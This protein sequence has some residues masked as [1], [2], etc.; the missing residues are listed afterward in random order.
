MGRDQGEAGLNEAQ[1][2][3]TAQESGTLKGRLEAVLFVAGEPVLVDDL[4][5]ALNETR[6]KVQMALSALKEEYDANQRGFC[7]RLF[8]E[9]VQLTTRPLYAADVVHLLQPVQKQ[10]LSQAIMETLAVVAYR[11]PVTKAE[12]EAIRGVKCDYSVQ[13]LTQKGLIV[14][15]GR[16]DALGKPILYGT[17]DTFLQRFGIESLEELPPMPEARSESEDDEPAQELMV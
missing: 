4:A 10:T 2:A 1:S 8:G 16:K 14:E 9:H 7:L 17:M 13:S 11:Q 12:I 3:E 5:K 15:V 6:F